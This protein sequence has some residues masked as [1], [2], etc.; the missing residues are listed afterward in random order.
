[1]HGGSLKI[2]RTV[3]LIFVYLQSFTEKFVG[4]KIHLLEYCS[5]DISKTSLSSDKE[6][7]KTPRPQ[8]SYKQ[9]NNTPR[10]QVSYKLDNNTPRPQ[11]SYKQDNNTPRPQVS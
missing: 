10:P 5:K 7:N 9:D 2:T 1:M 6:D 11:V 3:P 8:V 4:G